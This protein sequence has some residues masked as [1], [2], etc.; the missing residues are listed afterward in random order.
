MSTKN[1]SNKSTTKKSNTKSNMVTPS[2]PEKEPDIKISDDVVSALGTIASQLEVISKKLSIIADRLECLNVDVTDEFGYLP[3]S[4]SVVSVASDAYLNVYVDQRLKHI[5]N[6]NGSIT[7][8]GD[9]KV[10]N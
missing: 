6:I 7:V 3:V 4:A 9:L 8:D 5:F 10:N 2:I 1:T